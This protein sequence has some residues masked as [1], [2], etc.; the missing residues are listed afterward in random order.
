MHSRHLSYLCLIF[1]S[2]GADLELRMIVARMGWTIDVVAH[3]SFHV[4]LWRPASVFLFL[5]VDDIQ[6]LPSTPS[7]LHTIPT[8]CD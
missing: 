1:L 3:V 6:F 5:I 2:K 8:D 4:Q 7:H